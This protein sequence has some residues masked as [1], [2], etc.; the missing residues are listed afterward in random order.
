MSVIVR[1]PG[2]MIK[3][4][5]KGA[6][7]A[8]F[9]RLQDLVPESGTRLQQKI[10]QDT[11]AHLDSFAREG[12]RT[13]CCAEAIIPNHIYEQWKEV[14]QK[15]ATS[16]ANRNE[17]LSEA[18]NLIEANLLLLGASAIE[19]KLQENVTFYNI[20]KNIF[21]SKEKSMR[22]LFYFEALDSFC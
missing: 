12:F 8:I 7:K 5:C 2:N 20:F 14:Y 16:M 18:A 22:V 6:D 10:R 9:E 19:D 11:K 17:K 13:L 4:F 15:A 1:T 3:L 21:I